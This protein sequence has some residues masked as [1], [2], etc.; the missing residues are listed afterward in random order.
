MT[1][2]MHRITWRQVAMS[3][4]FGFTAFMALGAPKVAYAQDCPFAPCTDTPPPPPPPCGSPGGPTCEPPPQEEGPVD[5]PRPRATHPP[6]ATT[7]PSAT[8]TPTASP[9]CDVTTGIGCPTSTPSFTPTITLVPTSTAFPTPT[10]LPPSPLVELITTF[11]GKLFPDPES[12]APVPAWMQPPNLEVTD[13]EITQVIQCMHNLLCSDNSVPLF[14]G[15]LTMVRAYV[16]VKSPPDGY[17][18]GIGGALCYGDTGSAGCENPIRPL[19]KIPVWEDPDP[20]R[21]ARPQ[22]VYALD[23]ILPSYFVT[24]GATKT[25]TVYANYNFEDYPKETY[26][27]DNHRLL[28]YQVEP[29]EPINVRYH[30]VQNL[31]RNNL[32]FPNQQQFVMADAGAVWDVY[33]F[34]DL[35]Y[36]TSEIHMTQGTPLLFRDYDTALGQNNRRKGWD[37]LLLDLWLLRSGSGPIHYGL[38]PSVTLRGAG[39][40]GAADGSMVSG[41]QDNAEAGKTA[42]QEIGHN[43]GRAHPPGCDAGGPDPNYPGINGGIDEVGTDVLHRK[44]Y[45]PSWVYDYM[46]YC[47][48]AAN[49]WTSIYTY[50]AMAGKL[51]AGVNNPAAGRV[52]APLSADAIVL[53]G[54]GEVSPEAALLE[55]GFYRVTAGPSMEQT[56][57][58]G[59]YVVDLLDRTGKVLTSRRFR[60]LAT[61]ND[62]PSASGPFAIIVAWV[63]GTVAVAFRYQDL[64]IGRI[65]TSRHGPEAS[66]VSPSENQ[67]W[68]ASGLQ[69]LAW[70]ASDGDGD[71]LQYLLQYSSD[72]GQSW[73]VLAPNLSDK[74]FEIDTAWLPGSENAR[75]RLIASDGL[76][77]IQVDSASFQVGGKPPMVHISGPTTD[78]MLIA[79]STAVL[80]GAATDLEDGFLGDDNLSW[81]SDQDGVLGTGRTAILPSLSEGPHKLTLT[82]IDSDG[83]AA[84]ES[85]NVV[86]QPAS[87]VEAPPPTSAAPAVLCLAVVVLLGVAGVGTAFVLGRRSRSVQK[88]KEA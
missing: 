26:Y 84:T 49:S 29:S 64:E 37:D 21:Y 35:T 23:F 42:A 50:E 46:G 73:S 2:W 4:V 33:D 63:D 30:L 7:A 31:N 9:T 32:N 34:L 87:V 66:F 70:T 48:V 55:H 59:P 38:M 80:Q 82:A 81:A 79:G 13:L 69:T 20:M 28:Q 56:P 65:E 19:Y 27:K 44:L 15:K 71:P 10:K 76:N 5:T 75:L 24:G 43:L 45:E 57:D 68:D 39:G 67:A 52:A 58:E 18:S 54:S 16:R 41:G 25:V 8:A 78:D 36:P 17:A 51:P 72:G 12:M 1:K 77:S 62:E 85:V 22:L 11:V 47:G 88:P 40:I 74:S 60:P 61:S 83:N 14:S 86:V 6:T 53:M 3:A